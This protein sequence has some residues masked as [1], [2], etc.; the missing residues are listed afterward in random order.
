MYHELNGL[1]AIARNKQAEA[2]N[3]RSDFCTF[4]FYP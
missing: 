4:D 2:R 3:S 1:C